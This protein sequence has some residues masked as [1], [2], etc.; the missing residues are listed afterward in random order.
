VVVVYWYQKQARRGYHPGKRG[1][2]SYHR[3]VCFEG[4][5]HDYWAGDLRP[6]DAHTTQGA[7]ELLDACIAKLARRP[8]AWT[9]EEIRGSTTSTAPTGAP[10]AVAS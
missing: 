6:G 3:M 7:L 4:L 5:S 8:G 9:S 1:R 10:D 2:L